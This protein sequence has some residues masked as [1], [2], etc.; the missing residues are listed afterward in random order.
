[1]K[2]KQQQ[3]AGHVMITNS[4]RIIFLDNVQHA[5]QPKTGALRPLIMQPI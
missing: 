3:I 1:M 5:I 2:A 4:L